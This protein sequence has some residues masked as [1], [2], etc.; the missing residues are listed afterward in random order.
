MSY[1]GATVITNLFSAI[2]LVGRYIVE[3][4]WGGYTVNAN[5]LS[6]FFVFHFLAPI[7][8]LGLAGVHVL[9]LHST[10][11]SNPL[12]ARLFKIKF[13]LFFTVKDLL[14]LI[15]MLWGL[16]FI[17]CF[18]PYLLGDVENFTEANPLVT[19]VHIKPE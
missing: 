13:H 5:T 18:Y 15:M 6:R 11:S 4:L 16:F 8:L 9:Y 12:G 2:P 1:W 17:S 7:L 19:P 3:W 14:S 10:G